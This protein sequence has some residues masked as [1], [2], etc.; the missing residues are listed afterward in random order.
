MKNNLK[1]NWMGHT[2]ASP[3]LYRAASNGNVFTRTEKL[4]M[5]FKQ[6]E[7]QER[8][9]ARQETILMEKAKARQERESRERFFRG[10]HT[11]TENPDAKVRHGK[12]TVYIQP[13]VKGSFGPKIAL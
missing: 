7:A 6:K 11:L 5:I 1:S 9:N 10:V 3:T 12:D 8:K 13:R 2:S 4:K